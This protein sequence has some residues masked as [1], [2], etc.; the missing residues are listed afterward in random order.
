MTVSIGGPDPRVDMGG[1]DHEQGLFSSMFGSAL[2]MDGHNSFETECVPA[3][4]PCTSLIT[5]STR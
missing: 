4:F 1:T 2:G 5:A 3:P